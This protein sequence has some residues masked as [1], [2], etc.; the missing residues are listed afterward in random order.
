MLVSA[1][2]RIVRW[3]EIFC[4]ALAVIAL[5]YMLG[6]VAFN[7]VARTVFDMTGTA[8]NFMIPGAIEQVSYLLGIIVLA[9]IAVSMKVGMI[10]V[11]ILVG[12]LPTRA[13]NYVARFW[14]FGVVA[15][16]VVVGWQFWEEAHATFSRGEETQ[17][18]RIPMFLI[19]GLYSIE[20]FALA[21]VALR[22]A[23]TNTGEHVELL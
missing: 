17:D 22:E 6:I 15:L 5:L 23:L 16:A 11:D 18:L 3:V 7:V 8:V 14:F 13:R 2:G 20:C 4:L 10:S 1:L 19:Y 12:R 21:I 9:A